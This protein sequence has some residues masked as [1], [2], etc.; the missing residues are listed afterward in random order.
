M[1]GRMLQLLGLLQG[2]REWS[3]AELAERLGV[4]DRTVRRDVDRLRELGYPVDGTTGTAGGYRLASGR[5]L[6][7]LL[8]DDDEAVAVAVGLL[9]AAGV[10]GIEDT[11]VQALAK[12]QQVLPAHLRARVA[13]VGDATALIERDGTPGADAT[14]LATIATACRDHELVTFGYRRRDGTSARRRVEPYRLVTAYGHRWYL[15]AFDPERA[16]WRTF[17]VDRITE[18]APTRAR[19]PPREMPADAADY[20]TRAITEAPYRYRAIA[21]VQ[22]PAEAVTARL[23]VPLPGRVRALDDATCTVS[24]GADSLDLLIKDLVA[25]GAEFTLDGPAELLAEVRAVGR[26]LHDAGA[27]GTS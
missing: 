17:R 2:R 27:A 7:P 15:L 1:P 5:N 11:A 16:G 13:A 14:V 20:V 18:V 8:L 19:F 3:G 24:M 4:T 10:T 9:T 25:L 22:A 26:R 6:P 12:L 21:T 23:T